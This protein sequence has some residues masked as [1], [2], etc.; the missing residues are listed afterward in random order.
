MLYIWLAFE[1]GDCRALARYDP[2]WYQQEKHRVRSA[3]SLACDIFPMA[4][5]NGVRRLCDTPR[6][7]HRRN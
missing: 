2:C 4:G 6:R 7:K 3:C 1:I 5:F